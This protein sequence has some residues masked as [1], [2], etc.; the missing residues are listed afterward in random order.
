MENMAKQHTTGGDK[1]INNSNTD[2]GTEERR[3]VGA[4]R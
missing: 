1:L 4:S 3:A 2:T